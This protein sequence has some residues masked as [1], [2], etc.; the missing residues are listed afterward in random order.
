VAPGKPAQ[1][2]G[3]RTLVEEVGDDHDEGPPAQS[4]MQSTDCIRE[5]GRGLALAG[6][7]NGQQHPKQA[8]ET[9]PP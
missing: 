8:E 2:L 5:S 3:P 9:D 7:G 1:F 6:T 4:V